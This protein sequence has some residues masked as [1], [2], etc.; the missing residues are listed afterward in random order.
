MPRRDQLVLLAD[1]ERHRPV[2]AEV[3]VRAIE[4]PERQRE[5]GGAEP[6]HR[7]HEWIGRELRL[8]R[9]HIGQRRNQHAAD[10]DRQQHGSRARGRR[11]AASASCANAADAGSGSQTS[12]ARRRPQI[13]FARNNVIARH[14]QR[15]SMNVPSAPISAAGPSIVI[16]ER[17]KRNRPAS[18][19]VEVIGVAP[20]VRHD[21]LMVHAH[22]ADA[23]AAIGF[24]LQHAADP[25]HAD[26]RLAVVAVVDALLG[27]RIELVEA[28]RIG[29]RVKLRP[30]DRTRG[31]HALDVAPNAGGIRMQAEFW[32]GRSDG[33]HADLRPARAEG[34]IEFKRTGN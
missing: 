34:R 13:S 15:G 20:L 21:E 23:D 7:R 19:H 8:I 10:R 2:A 31:R 22:E 5:H 25:D 18:H 1:F 32:D 26:D 17:T 29:A 28:D 33:H 3:A 30:F 14:S 4:Q 9:N 11:G 16:T 27:H 24:R 12:R 6:G